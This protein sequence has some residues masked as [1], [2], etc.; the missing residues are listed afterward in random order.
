[1]N[2]LSH[3]SPLD[4]EKLSLFSPWLHILQCAMKEVNA[5]IVITK[6]N[7]YH[8]SGYRQPC[9]VAHEYKK[10]LAYDDYENFHR[11]LTLII[12][13]TSLW[14]FVWW[15]YAREWRWWWWWWW[16][17]WKSKYWKNGQFIRLICERPLFNKLTRLGCKSYGSSS[18]LGE[19]CPLPTRHCKTLW[20]CLLEHSW[21][22]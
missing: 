5:P 2:R 7:F 8:P 3:F 17:W 14:D 15:E 18:Q 16:W 21:C 12:A 13:K 4:I 19:H 20:A 22:A 10:I 6:K 11:V 9:P 1:M